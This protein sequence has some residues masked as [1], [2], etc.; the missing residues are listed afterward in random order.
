MGSCQSGACSHHRARMGGGKK[1]EKET[2]H[3]RWSHSFGTLSAHS[4]LADA[5]SAPPAHEQ[6]QHDCALM[7][8]DVRAIG[9]ASHSRLQSFEFSLPEGKGIRLWVE[10]ASCFFLF[11]TLG[12]IP[13]CVC[14]RGAL[15]PARAPGKLNRARGRKILH[16]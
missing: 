8:H 10:A 6:L 9:K 15:A 5:R 14:G 11:L 3:T 7:E 4:S 13:A 2:C 1:K 16:L 12:F